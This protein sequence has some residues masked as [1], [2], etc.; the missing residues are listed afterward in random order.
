L[1]DPDRMAVVSHDATFDFVAHLPEWGLTFPIAGNGHESGSL[2]N[3]W[4]GTLP[5]AGPKPGSTVWGVVYS[6]PE[7]DRSAI[8]AAEAAEGRQPLEV[9][10]IDRTGKR[11][12][13]T[14]YVAESGTIRAVQPSPDYLEIMVG[15]SRHWDLPAGWIVGLEDHLG[16]EL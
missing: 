10:V 7:S 5:S 6:V 4:S 9:E 13:V 12:A 2:A 14:A 16:V 1:I 11:H 8:D 3:D 15:G